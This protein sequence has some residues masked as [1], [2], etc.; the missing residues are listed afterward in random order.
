LR[1]RIARI[2][3]AVD[4][5]S[6]RGVVP[7]GVREVDARLPQG[8]LARGALHEIAGG[9]VGA[10]HGAAAVYGPNWALAVNDDGMGMY[11]ET[12]SATPGLGTSIVETLARQLRARVQVTD[13]KPGTAVSTIHTQIGAVGALTTEPIGRAV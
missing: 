3:H 13:A 12:A 5:R 9:G 6:D 10:V 2:E 1:A 8:G 11:L 4:G 7:F